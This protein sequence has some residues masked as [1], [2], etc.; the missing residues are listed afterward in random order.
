MMAMISKISKGR[1]CVSMDNP[2]RDGQI[3]TLKVY[4]S[5]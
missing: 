5:F 1:Y 4:H 3:S 2:Y